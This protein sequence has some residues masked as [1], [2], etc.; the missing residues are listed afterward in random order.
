MKARTKFDKMVVASNERLTAISPKAIEWAMKHLIKHP[1][2]RVASSLTTCGD[3][4]HKFRHEG[5]GL[6]VVC[7]HCGHRLEIN[8]TPKRTKK[9]RA[10]FASL[11]AYFINIWYSCIFIYSRTFEKQ[12]RNK[13]DE[14]H[15]FVPLPVSLA[16]FPVRYLHFCVWMKK[17]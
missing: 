3:C 2:F 15:Y 13:S 16:F 8:D 6:N 7:P 4:G 10:Y 9:D 5:K 1:A 14:K 17:R 12:I 11:T